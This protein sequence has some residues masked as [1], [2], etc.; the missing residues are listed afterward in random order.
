MSQNSNTLMRRVASPFKRKDSS[1]LTPAE[2]RYS[3]Q[4]EKALAFFETVL[5]WADY[6]SFLHKLQKALSGFT[7]NWIPQSFEVARAL[8]RCLSPTLPSGV[9]GK[10]LETYAL[11]FNILGKDKL[12]EDIHMWLPGLLPLMSHAAIAI[13]PQLLQL[14]EHQL[15]RLDARNLR[16]LAKPLI[17]SLLPGLDDEGAESF[18]AVLKVLEDLKVR[19]DN[20][21]HFWQCLFLCIVTSADKRQG[22]LA[23]CTRKLPDFNFQER[24]SFLPHEA[25]SCVSPDVGLLIRAF[26]EALADDNLFVQRG[27]F[28]LL[29]TRIELRSDVLQ[30]LCSPS[31]REKLVMSACSTVARKDMSLNRRL[32][33]WLLGPDEPEESKTNEN[34]PEG[35]EGSTLDWKTHYF[36]R[37]GLDSLSTGL[38]NLIHG[39]K[40]RGTADSQKTEAFRICLAIM[41]KWEIGHLIIPRVFLPALKSCQ[42]A[43]LDVL[44][45]AGA[46]FDAIEAF[47]IWSDLHKLVDTDL[48]L[49][50]FALQHFNVDDEEMMVQHMPL[51]FLRLLV[52][53]ESLCDEREIAQCL[54]ICQEMITLIPERAF[55]PIDVGMKTLTE[56]PLSANETSAEISESSS[57]SVLLKLHQYYASQ[58][59]A[60]PYTHADLTA[61]LL[62]RCAA[63]VDTYLQKPSPQVFRFSA[64]LCDLVS[65][66]PVGATP[67]RCYALYDTISSLPETTSVPLALAVSKLFGPVVKACTATEKSR[68]VKCTL[69]K[70]WDVM[71][72]HKGKYQVEAVRSIWTMEMSV[73]SQYI[74]AGLCALLLKADPR[75][76]MLA[77]NTLWT[78]TALLGDTVSLLKRPIWLVLD[79]L[80]AQGTSQRDLCCEWILTVVNGG[81]ANRFFNV[82]TQPLFHLSF[83]TGETIDDLEATHY[84]L[85]TVVNVLRVTPLV[86]TALNNEL[87]TITDNLSL[88]FIQKNDWDV[89]TY[90]SLLLSVCLRF[91]ALSPPEEAINDDIYGMCV[92]DALDIIELLVDGSEGDF[93]KIIASTLQ[94]AETFF[95]AGDSQK[96]TI[97]VQY[98]ALAEK[99]LVMAKH[100]RLHLFGTSSRLVGFLVLGIS[101]AEASIVVHHWVKLLSACLPFFSESLFL[102]VFRLCDCFCRKITDIFSCIEGVL[103]GVSMEGN[104]GEAERSISLLING[105]ESLLL[106]TH[107]RLGRPDEA[108][109]NPGDTGF[110]GSVLQGVFQS[111]NLAS[112]SDDNDRL[113][114]LLSFQNAI[115]VCFGIWLWSEERTKGFS[116][117]EVLSGKYGISPQDSTAFVATRL[118]F[119]CKK[120]METLNALEPLETLESLVSYKSSSIEY[121]SLIFKILN[122]L[123]GG[124]PL[125]TFESILQTL[126]SHFSDAPSSSLLNPDVP[127]TKVAHL[128][129]GYVEFLD[130]DVVEEL[131]PV[132]LVFLKEAS[133]LASY[134]PI[135][136]D[137]LKLV[138]IVGHKLHKSSDR[139]QKREMADVFTKIALLA[140][141]LGSRS[142]HLGLAEKD[143]PLL[144]ETRELSP[145]LASTSND[146]MVN[147]MISIL[148]YIPDLLTDS[149]RITAFVNSVVSG[150]VQPAFKGKFA[151]SS[152]LLRLLIE[153]G[154]LNQTKIWRLVVSELFMDASFFG[155]NNPEYRE[156]L[157]TWAEPE[158]DDRLA[159]LLFRVQ[160]YNPSSTLF[161]WNE[162]EITAR[163]LHLRRIVYLIMIAPRDFYM[164]TLDDLMVRLA[165]IFHSPTKQLKRDAFV[166]LRAVLLRFT[167]SHLVQYWPSII[168]ALQSLFIEVMDGND[169]SIDVVLGACKLL[170]ML[171]MVAPEE[172]QLYQWLFIT[173]NAD[174]I[175]GDNATTLSLIDRLSKMDMNDKTEEL[176]PILDVTVN[177][178][179]TDL[180]AKRPLLVG[181]QRVRRLRNLKHFFE[182]LSIAFYELVYRGG[183]L[184]VKSCEEDVFSDLFF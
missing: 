49:V 64:L 166:C 39:S 82:I 79:D 121:E 24:L 108:G 97:E 37:Y 42:E 6:I 38:L 164:S 4:I 68:L 59:R 74:E 32:W 1:L 21:N 30:V 65:K 12:N 10:T 54:E 165:E 171:I 142:I 132:A 125:V 26:C 2:R 176:E 60:F 13:K 50:S 16:A 120:L 147:C 56:I 72:E 156:L 103:Y 44:T 158:K 181:V 122:G 135:Y 128:L 168:G 11:A 93:E 152:Q 70:L 88:E 102:A 18:D 48:T 28:D 172:F 73:D 173:D 137:L 31:D 139:K 119:R 22:A 163:V 98:L 19:I 23:W 155:T 76:R 20:D 133:V 36:Q 86:T 109:L 116:N 179:S 148:P 161:N 84:H 151:V 170:D 3:Q 34:P 9:H 107:Q 130:N 145:E 178:N 91:L 124:K 110:F 167:H 104:L 160:P 15:L 184:D 138:A 129:V 150:L 43:S 29:V 113:S 80:A 63:L 162:V 5:E 66:I 8:G 157:V 81:T 14:Y 7:H 87:V 25:R 169:D 146:N 140:V 154:S 175:Y 106:V 99:V 180:D 118:K 115:K 100:K 94:S 17:L 141:N 90:K 85:S 182:G 78:H 83:L 40:T 75:R 96:Q 55:L 117:N 71:L 69:D 77:I 134:K 112:K 105:L 144:S 101:K 57:V 61:S 33:K 153:L 46:L 111:D 58:T 92:R 127:E 136:P 183:E 62:D 177:V 123:D 114:L 67:W 143:K 89:S 47:D 27:F 131:W 95:D 126:G 41:D 174:A 35:L 159:D 45:S 52:K 51:L 53:C 149:D